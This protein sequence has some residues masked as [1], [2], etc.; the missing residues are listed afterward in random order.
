[1]MVIV[2]SNG[3]E[4]KMKKIIIKTTK[5]FNRIQKCLKLVFELDGT[6]TSINSKYDGYKGGFPGNLVFYFPNIEQNKG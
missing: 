1:M 3:I 5:N 6:Y 2:P 4:D